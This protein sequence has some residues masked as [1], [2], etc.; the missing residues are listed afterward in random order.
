[1]AV[2]VITANGMKK[3]SKERVRMKCS[4]REGAAG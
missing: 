2:A 1:M 3:D 4:F